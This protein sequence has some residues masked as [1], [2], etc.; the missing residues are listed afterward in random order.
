MSTST[1]TWYLA[2]NPLGQ[3][4]RG[5]SWV[6]DIA[7]ARLYRNVGPAKSATTKWVK[8]NP[9]QPIPEILE[10]KLDVATATVLDVAGETQKRI[11][12]AAKAKEAREREHAKYEWQCLE[13]EAQRNSDARHKLAVKWGNL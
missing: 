5:E 11:M 1:V 3:F 7:D 4:S 9:G 6:D 10:W 8:Q 13:R 12:R 2:R